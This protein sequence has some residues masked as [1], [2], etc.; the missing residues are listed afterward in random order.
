MNPTTFSV[1]MELLFHNKLRNV[2][3]YYISNTIHILLKVKIA[4]KSFGT[5]E[6]EGFSFEF[7]MIIKIC[8]YFKFYAFKKP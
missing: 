8:N 2:Q 5:F 4:K 3:C 7:R 6:K 1:S